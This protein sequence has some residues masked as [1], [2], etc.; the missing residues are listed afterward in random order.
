MEQLEIEK[1]IIEKDGNSLNKKLIITIVSII[2]IIL[3][4]LAIIAIII[5]SQE[6]YTDPPVFAY[7][8]TLEELKYRTNETNLTTIKLLEKNSS[9]YNNLTEEE[10][11][12]LKLLIEAAKLIEDIHLQLD[13][14]K[15]KDF[16]D[17]LDRESKKNIQ[18]A[19]LTNKLFEVQKGISSYDANGNIINLAKD[20][21][22][23]PGLGVYPS[24][25]NSSQIIDILYNMAS[26]NDTNEIQ[27]VK[28]IL[29]QRT[30]VLKDG[31]DKLKSEDYITHF[32]AQFNKIADKL[33]EA[34]NKL[35]TSNNEDFKKYLKLQAEALKDVDPE[36][37]AKADIKW[38]ELK[39]TSLEFTLIRENSFD[40]MTLSIMNDKNLMELLESKNI[41][42]IPKDSLG[43]RVGIVDKNRTKL[44]NKINEK[45]PE[46]E[47]QMPLY[48]SYENNSLSKDAINISY[49]DVDLVSLTGIIGAFR[50][51][52]SQS[53]ILPNDDKKSIK[54]KRG[55]KRHVFHRQIIQQ[56][57]SKYENGLLDKILIN[58]QHQYYDP[59]SFNLFLL[60][61]YI[62]QNLGPKIENNTLGIYGFI[63]EENKANLVSLAFLDYF[64]D[65]GFYEEDD[66]KKI[67]ITSIINMHLSSKPDLEEYTSVPLVMTIN[68]FL[69]NDACKITED[70]KIQIFEDKISSV[71]NDMLNKIIDIQLNNNFTEA[72]IF[73]EKY[74]VWSEDFLQ[75]VGNHIKSYFTELAYTYQRSEF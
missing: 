41:T 12:A 8:L 15:N 67:M 38:A 50:G 5:I 35:T 4:V 74:F 6:E 18:Q 71:S 19:I 3:I 54:E 59:D 36:S 48:E 9:Q 33:E 63:L 52:V 72:K 14:E 55:G 13:N 40:E 20:Y 49:V 32:K 34:A 23:P 17:F 62:G 43:I 75:I 73:V 29:S 57:Y 16:K 26:S 56:Y 68:Y 30:I 46:L 53:E 21:P 45:L 58:E 22:T 39:D 51:F 70:K 44:M 42:P 69:E 47:Q 61:Y 10:K 7:G 25:L 24:D 27:K 2:G 65:E 60:G 11:E 31:N 37:D 66:I 28:D 1:P 64:K